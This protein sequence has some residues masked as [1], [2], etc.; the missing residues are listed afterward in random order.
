[1]NI[2]SFQNSIVSCEWQTHLT[3]I[4]IVD[5]DDLRPLNLF[6]R[7]Y[8]NCTVQFISVVLQCVCWICVHV[9][10]EKMRIGSIFILYSFVLCAW[11]KIKA[12]TCMLSTCLHEKRVQILRHRIISQMETYSWVAFYLF[13]NA[14]HIMYFLLHVILFNF[15]SLSMFI[16]PI[17]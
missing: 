14:N 13:S 17:K 7:L 9:L 15:Y 12:K 1:M 16:Y 5:L 8:V 4:I 10:H 3:I 6:K 11:C 2:V